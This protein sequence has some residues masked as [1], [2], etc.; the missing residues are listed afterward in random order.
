MCLRSRTRQWK[1]KSE[2]T[3][4]SNLSSDSIPYSQLINIYK[5]GGR[6][7]PLVVYSNWTDCAGQIGQKQERTPILSEFYSGTQRRKLSH[8]KH[9]QRH[10]GIPQTKRTY[11]K[12]KSEANRISTSATV[13]LPTSLIAGIVFTISLICHLW[14]KQLINLKS[15]FY[16]KTL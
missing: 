8:Q 6:S 2:T 5:N 9:P 14:L 15:E 12:I 10:Q 3:L 13:N 4:A 11:F 1:S 16:R 7:F